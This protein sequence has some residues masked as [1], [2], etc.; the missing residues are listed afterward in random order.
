MFP[1][2]FFFA[3][4][5]RKKRSFSY[6]VNHTKCD[7]TK[8]SARNNWVM[9]V[10][11]TV[12]PILAYLLVPTVDDDC[13][14]HPPVMYWL[15]LAH[16]LT[17]RSS[18]SRELIQERIPHAPRTYHCRCVRFVFFFLNSLSLPLRAPPK[19]P[20]NTQQK[21]HE[22][23]IQGKNKR[24]EPRRPP[25]Y[26]CTAVA[27]RGSS[28]TV[29]DKSGQAI[30]LFEALDPLTREGKPSAIPASSPPTTVDRYM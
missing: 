15:P 25:R 30:Q 14:A 3:C 10:R 6:L 23:P 7:G 11:C 27:S 28:C 16:P 18:S 24:A 26:M 17:H 2:I 1:G 19:L 4:L 29:T 8:H 21:Q 5:D 20:W 12:V 22:S 13:A 9:H